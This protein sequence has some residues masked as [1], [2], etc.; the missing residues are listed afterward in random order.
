[1]GI[2]LFCNPGYLE[3]I[4]EMI[5]KCNFIYLVN[6]FTL[7]SSEVDNYDMGEDLGQ[8]SL[9]AVNGIFTVSV[10]LFTEMAICM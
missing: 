8:W 6:T 2:S 10:N 7:E 5:P 9:S 1:M 4:V 3:G